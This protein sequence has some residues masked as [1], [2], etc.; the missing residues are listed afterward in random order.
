M[1]AEL[2]VNF[3]QDI[4]KFLPGF[5]IEII[6]FL[7]SSVSLENINELKLVKIK[8]ERGLDNCY[9]PFLTDNGSEQLETKSLNIP[10][11]C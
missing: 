10:L 1:L 8:G 2:P 6:V 3:V 4:K 11:W 5:K 9:V 7:Y